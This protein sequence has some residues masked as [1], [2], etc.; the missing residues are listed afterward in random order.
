MIKAKRATICSVSGLELTN[1]VYDEEKKE[2]AVG[3]T[4]AM[5]K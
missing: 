5:N 1:G 2:Q 3:R 4:E